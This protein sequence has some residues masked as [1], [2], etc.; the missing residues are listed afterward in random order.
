MSPKLEIF[1]QILKKREISAVIITDELNIGY[2]CDFRFSDG[3]L[4][5][6][7]EEAYL[8]TDFRYFEEAGAR[9]ADAFKVVMPDDRIAFIKDFLQKGDHAHLGFE[10]G[11]MTVAAYNRYADLLPVSL[12]PMGDI[13]I[14]MRAVKTPAEIEKI[15]AAQAITDQAFDHIL[16]TIT[17]DITEREIALELSYFMKK[18]GAEGDSFE[19]IAVSGDASALPHGKCRNQKVSKGFL[20]MDFGCIYDGYCS[21]MTRT[22]CIGKADKEMKRLYE[23]VL[24]AQAEA[25]SVI[26]AGETGAFVDGVARGYIERAG[27]KNAFGHGLGHGVGLYIHEVPS[28]SFRATEKRLEAGNIVTVEPGIYLM[29]K[30]GCR[31]EDMGLVTNDGFENFTHSP[32]EL[33]ELFA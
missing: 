2:L 23:T 16:H 17:P 25:L 18:M 20:T 7:G 3:F 28:L 27:Y 9:C 31:I 10:S 14:E 21:D 24:R 22:V 5:I 4:L 26:K 1:R 15:K 6:D 12:L 19:I 33:I 13:L 30:Y 29:G 32:K 8:V 11:T